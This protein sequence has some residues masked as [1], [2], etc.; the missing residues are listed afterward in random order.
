MFTRAVKRVHRPAHMSA[1]LF[2]LCLSL[3]V[4]LVLSSCSDRSS[5]QASSA[6]SATTK[7]ASA[8]NPHPTL[9][10]LPNKPQTI[11][12]QA[13]KVLATGLQAPWS[14]VPLPDGSTL[15]GERNSGQVLDI[16]ASGTENVIGTIQNVVAKGESGLLGLAAR[17]EDCGPTH[18]ATQDDKCLYLYAYL[19]TSSDN[20]VVKMPLAGNASSRT[21]GAPS[22]IISGIPQGSN[23]DGGRI[24]FGPDGMLYIATGDAGHPEQAQK[25]DSLAGKI[26]RVTPTGAIPANN[27]FKGSPVWSLGHRNVEG[28]A[29]DSKGRMWASELGSDSWD[30]LNQIL[31]GKNYGWPAVEG[32]GKDTHYVD[33]VLV[34]HPA[35]ASPS[36]IAI[37]GTTLFMTSLRGQ[38]LWQIDLAPIQPSAK[39]LDVGKLGRLRDVAFSVTG[40]LLLITSNTDGRGTPAKGDD[41][42]LAFT[43]ELNN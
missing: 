23:H 9:P 40:Q 36:G 15:V 1:G 25:I 12:A 33:P 31:P 27:P 21:L 4:V 11:T 32:L 14:I 18:V 39:I 26:L 7:S 28:I 37:H 22:T 30:E 24:A 38:K 34:W 42:L 19:T 8:E 3:P 20:R 16:S 43:L 17:A 41:K 5:D 10:Q 2:F 13:G 35:D 29:W 6:S